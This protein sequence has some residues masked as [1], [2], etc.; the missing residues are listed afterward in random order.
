[1]PFPGAHYLSRGF[2]RSGKVLCALGSLSGAG[3]IVCLCQVAI[4]LPISQLWFTVPCSRAAIQA[5]GRLLGKRWPRLPS[6]CEAVVG[7]A[8]SCGWHSRAELSQAFLPVMLTQS[9]QGHPSKQHFPSLFLPTTVLV[10]CVTRNF[11]KNYH[12]TSVMLSNR[13]FWW[14]T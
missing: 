4:A 10:S 7:P 2:M 9:E 1:M 12:A 14:Q 11:K 13:I 6:A 8:L 5:G 3:S